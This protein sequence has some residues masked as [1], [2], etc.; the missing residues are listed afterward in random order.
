MPHLSRLLAT[1]CA[2]TVTLVSLPTDAGI[3]DKD[4]PL[5]YGQKTKL[6]YTVTGVI[7]IAGLATAFHCTSTERTGGKT[8]ELGVEVFDF[9]GNLKN[10]VAAG[11]GVTSLSP[12]ETATLT[13]QYTLVFFERN[14]IGTGQI[15]QGSARIFSNSK[16]VIC[17]AM[18]LDATNNPPTV[19]V[20]LPVFKA[21]KQGG[22]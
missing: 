17:T 14:V 10:N 4:L 6:L 19:M 22:M 5:L 11:D 9:G 12:G 15:F 2:I 13:T 18:V 3:G 8:V 20:M 7:D 21:T 1:I 16:N